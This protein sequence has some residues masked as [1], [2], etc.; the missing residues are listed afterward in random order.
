MDEISEILKSSW[1]AEEWIQD[2]WDTINSEEKLLIQHRMDDLFKDGLPF[3]LKHEKILYIYTFSLLA[4]MEALAIQIPLKFSSKMPTLEQ[5]VCMRSQLLDEIFHCLAFTKIAYMLSAPHAI[6]PA[7]NKKIAEFFAFL[8]D[9]ECP[10]VALI[11]VN[12][13]G[14]GCVEEVFNSLDRR[15][16]APRLLKTI[17]ADE[18]RHVDEAELYLA[19]GLPDMDLFKHKLTLFEDLLINNIF[20]QYK[21]MFSLAALLGAKG[22]NE[23][24]DA[25][26]NKHQQ[27]LRK[28][29]LEPGDKW[30]FFMSFMKNMLLQFPSIAKDDELIEM[31][32]MRKVFMSQWDN[33]NDPTMCGEFN[34]NVSALEFFNKKYPSETITTLMLQTLSMGLSETDSFRNF[35]S[36]RKLYQAKE[37]SVGL[38]V[39]LPDCNDHIGMIILKNCHQLTTKDLAIKI[40]S[41]IKTMVFCYKKR[42]ELEFKYPHFKQIMDDIYYDIHNHGYDYP[43]PSHPIISLSNIG[44]CGYTQAKAPLARNESI[45]FTLMEIEKKPVWNKLT[46]IFEPQDLLPVSMSADHRVFDGNLPIPKITAHYFEK[47]FEKMLQNSGRSTLA[48]PSF[49]DNAKH[50]HQLEKMAKNN[51]EMAYKILLILQTYWH[52]DSPMNLNNE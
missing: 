48:S 10:K 29:N 9:E 30:Q 23:F 21:Y 49:I 43:M 35:L 4:Q 51:P 40:Q 46:Q 6:P 28:I 26:V 34:I 31:T 13:V 24:V 15:N 41:L 8:R 37:A 25:L 19:I 12:L 39:K 5:Q 11:L 32:P 17:L 14:E 45:K 52:D 22:I 38:V 18:S 20:S 36:M 42:E 2:C 33:P 44:Y 3:E 27:Q 47:T 7:F 16:I 50:A 1:G